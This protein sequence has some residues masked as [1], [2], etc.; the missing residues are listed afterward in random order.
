MKHARIFTLLSLIFFAGCSSQP[1]APENNSLLKSQRL[2]ELADTLAN[3]I[4][5]EDPASKDVVTRNMITAEIA[6]TK[7]ALAAEQAAQKNGL[8]GP[9]LSVME[10]VQGNVLL[11]DGMLYLSS[12][13]YSRP[14]LS[15]HL[16]LTTA[17][18]PRDVTFPDVTAVDLGALDYP[19]GPMAFAVH[20]D[21]TE[22]MRT[23]V[24]WDAKL[25]RLYGFAQL[26][27]RN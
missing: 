12:D 22:N 24:L 15:L 1:S 13:F 6:K 3:I 8:S 9:F 11:K 10:S 7:E 23:A 14:G 19:F 2:E 21:K 17:V 18:D 20:G 26:S 27:V 5:T 4:I 25:K 16:Y